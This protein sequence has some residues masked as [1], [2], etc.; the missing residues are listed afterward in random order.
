M[1]LK[2]LVVDD[3]TFMVKLAV[4]CLRDAGYDAFGSTSGWEA[5]EVLRSGETVDVVVTDQKMPGMKGTDLF[6]QCHQELGAAMPPFIMYTGSEDITS[7]MNAILAA[8]RMGFVDIVVK[9]PRMDRLLTA[10]EGVACQ[11]QIPT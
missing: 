2:V 3:V 7:D 9:S 5:L 11:L 6:R 10:L 8:K 4:R 1:P